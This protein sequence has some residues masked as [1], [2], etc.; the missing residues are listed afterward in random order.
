PEVTTLLAEKGATLCVSGTDPQPP[1]SLPPGRI[2]Y[3]RLRADHYSARRRD[4]W[5]DL[6]ERESES[7]D[8]YA[9]AKHEG[10]PA[11]D[12]FAGVGLAQ[13]LV[14]NRPR[15]GSTL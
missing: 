4:L 7:R 8:V 13:W 9:F 10:T 6:L 15:A 3:V 2:A 12:P 14:R 5:R 11:G 1:E